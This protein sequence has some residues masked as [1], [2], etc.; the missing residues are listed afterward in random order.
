MET[1]AQVADLS[2]QSD[3]LSS[4]AA[5][6]KHNFTVVVATDTSFDSLIKLDALCREVGVKLVACDVAGNV[7]Y[8]FND[9]LSGF[10]V[11]DVDGEEIKEVSFSR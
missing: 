6:S 5:L 10:Q 7:G 1:F 2:G 11:D 9:F 4:S 8:V 3:L